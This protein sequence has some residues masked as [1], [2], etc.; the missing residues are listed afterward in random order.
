MQRVLLIARVLSRSLSLGV[1]VPKSTTAVSHFWM[2]LQ[3]C[4]VC[5]RP[6]PAMPGPFSGLADIRNKFRA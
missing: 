2:Y 4:T 5:P 1:S 6:P 3:L